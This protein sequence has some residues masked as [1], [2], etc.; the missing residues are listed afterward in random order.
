MRKGGRKAAFF[1]SRGSYQPSCRA[2]AKRDVP[3]IHVLVTQKDV[4]GRDK[5]GHDE[6]VSRHAMHDQLEREDW[7]ASSQG[8][9][10][11]TA[12]RQGHFK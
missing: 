4:D 2:S 12:D 3:G 7:I 5:P 6:T 9:L 8:L 1:M 10:A 11:M